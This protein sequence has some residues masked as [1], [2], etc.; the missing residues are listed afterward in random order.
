[1][2]WEGRPTPEEPQDDVDAVFRDIVA[3]F[4]ESTGPDRTDPGDSEPPRPIGRAPG[5]AA[6]PGAAGGGDQ[7]RVAH[8][9]ALRDPHPGGPTGHGVGGGTDDERSGAGTGAT[10]GSEAGA[11]PD[12][13]TGPVPPA[14]LSRPL[15]LPEPS[16]WRMHHPPR[17]PEDEHFMPPRPAPPPGQDA[18]FWTALLSCV[19]GPLWFLYVV[20]TDPYG[21]RVSLW[22]AGLLTVCGCALTV[23]RLPKRADTDPDDDGARV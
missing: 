22:A 13:G 23:W 10:T 2:T 14:R 19:A 1:M 18:V 6:A 3:Q 21:S 5:D 12:P 16:P 8:P 11:E 7:F 17:D 9:G 4:G 15:G 20:L